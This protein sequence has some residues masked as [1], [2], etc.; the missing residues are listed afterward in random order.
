MLTILYFFVNTK[1]LMMA[2]DCYYDFTSG[3]VIPYLTHW[4]YA[5]MDV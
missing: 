3:V 4:T 1:T 2:L 5:Q